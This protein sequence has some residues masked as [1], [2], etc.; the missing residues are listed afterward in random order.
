[1]T[2]QP[3]RYIDSDLDVLYITAIADASCYEGTRPVVALGTEHGDDE[4]ATVYVELND[5]EKVI[6]AIRDAAA[7]LRH[8]ASQDCGD[9]DCGPC[10]FDRAI[11]TTQVGSAN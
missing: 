7:S 5:V 9:E 11:P 10:S 1:M 3:F 4:T 6:S 8:A 2:D